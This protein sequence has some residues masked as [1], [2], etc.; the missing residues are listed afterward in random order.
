MDGTVTR[1]SMQ[2]GRPRGATSTSGVLPAYLRVTVPSITPPFGLNRTGPDS[3]L[4]DLL[5]RYC[6]DRVGGALRKAEEGAVGD[7]CTGGTSVADGHGGCCDAGG[8][9]RSKG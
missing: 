8:A 9:A 3:D 5:T 7:G 6:R 2:G 4:P 1:K